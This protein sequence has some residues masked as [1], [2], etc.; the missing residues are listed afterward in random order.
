MPFTRAVVHEGLELCR[1]HAISGIITPVIRRLSFSRVNRAVTGL[2][3]S[4]GGCVRA[5]PGQPRAWAP[6]LFR[7]KDCID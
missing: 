1:H 7:K 3:L 2:R 4:A 5:C 6:G